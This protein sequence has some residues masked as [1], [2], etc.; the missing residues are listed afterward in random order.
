MCVISVKAL[1]VKGYAHTVWSPPSCV[2]RALG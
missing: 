1:F 2:T